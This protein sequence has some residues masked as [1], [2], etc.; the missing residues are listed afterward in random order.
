MHLS[1]LDMFRTQ[2]NL[3]STFDDEGMPVLDHAGKYA[4]VHVLLLLLF[5]PSF[6]F[7]FVVV[8]VFIFV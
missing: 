5:P 8:F 1:P 7:I 4:H 2:T 3:Y 6:H